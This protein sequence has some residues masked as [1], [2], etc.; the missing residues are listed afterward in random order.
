MDFEFQVKI[1]IS[2]ERVVDLIINAVE[3]GSGYWIRKINMSC[4]K[5]DKRYSY[6]QYADINF[7]EEG[8]FLTITDDENHPHKL[9]L[10]EI[11]TG[12]EIMN[13]LDNLHF[14]DIMI[15]NDDAITSD[16]F[17]QYCLFGEA[18]YS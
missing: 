18:I 17:L 12:L 16:R 3:L 14:N 6:P 9:S 1:S 8:G 15:E 11:K 7:W 5:F 13:R 10:A 2:I 4:S